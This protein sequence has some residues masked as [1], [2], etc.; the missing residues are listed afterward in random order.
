MFTHFLTERKSLWQFC[1]R[2]QQHIVELGGMKVMD[3]GQSLERT[4][5]SGFD[6]VV[7]QMSDK[8]SG[9]YPVL[10]CQLFDRFFGDTDGQA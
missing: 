4:L 9:I 2:S 7:L 3:L 6:A 8:S 1:L 5:W 10:L